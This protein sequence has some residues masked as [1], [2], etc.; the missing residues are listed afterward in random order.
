MPAIGFAMDS[1]LS[2]RRFPEFSSGAG[3]GHFSKIANFRGFTEALQRPYRDI[4]EIIAWLYDSEQTSGRYN[5][6]F[7]LLHE[8][9]ANPNLQTFHPHASL[10]DRDG[11][12]VPCTEFIYPDGHR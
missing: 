9:P 1:Y 6:Y 3:L 10:P 8:D 5:A 12:Y 2:F 4:I 11:Y 7:R